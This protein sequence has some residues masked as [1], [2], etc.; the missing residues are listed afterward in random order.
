MQADALDKLLSSSLAARVCALSRQQ[1][2][3]VLVNDAYKAKMHAVYA[4]DLAGVDATFVLHVRRSPF[5][6]ER[7]A[8][9]VGGRQQGVHTVVASL[10]VNRW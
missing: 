7:M 8:A 1:L 2:L 3:S 5:P 6:M 10:N 9:Q 4:G